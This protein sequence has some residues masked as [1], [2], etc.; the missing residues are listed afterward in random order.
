MKAGQ[1]SLK[2]LVVDVTRYAVVNTLLYCPTGLVAEK[3]TSVK[4][5]IRQ[6][7]FRSGDSRSHSGALCA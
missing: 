3:H 5:L 1:A 4:A 2:R 6:K 7:K